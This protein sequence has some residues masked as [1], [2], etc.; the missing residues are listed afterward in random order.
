MAGTRDYAAEKVAA[1]KDE[2]RERYI[3]SYKLKNK[4]SIIAA[5]EADDI[6]NA[7]AVEQARAKAEELARRHKAYQKAVQHNST[8][9]TGLTK[10]PAEI[11]NR[12][13]EYVSNLSSQLSDNLLGLWRKRLIVIDIGLVIPRN[14]DIANLT[15][16]LGPNK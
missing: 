7:V 15:R 9:K 8:V 12:I 6:K 14:R 4:Q 2:L 13:Y 10:L 5:L 11:R 16:A 1:L 3:Y